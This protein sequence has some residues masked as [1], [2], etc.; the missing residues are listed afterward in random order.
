MAAADDAARRQ[1]EALLFRSLI[2]PTDGIVSR[3]LNRP[4]SLRVTRLLINT[5]LTPNQMTLIAGGFGIAAIALVAVGGAAWLVPGAVLLQVQSILDGCDGEISRLKYIRSR[6]GEW[7]DQVLDDVVNVGF[8]A[9]AGWALHQAGS[10]IALPIAIVGT[11]FHLIYQGALYTALVTR[12]GGSGSITSI[13]WWG[14][15]DHTGPSAGRPPSGFVRVAKETIEAAM[16]RDFFTFLYLPA[17]LLGVT[18]AALGWCAFIF[19]GSGL[20]TG[21]QWLVGGGPEPAERTS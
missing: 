16:R 21:L 14:Q 13:R 1:G 10:G 9:A 2:K 17:A 4:I 3:A 18:E 15:K 5:P 20:A 19:V 6:L 12:G 8:F 7:L 11:A